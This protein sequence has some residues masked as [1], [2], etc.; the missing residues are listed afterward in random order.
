MQITDQ[1]QEDFVTPR[2]GTDDLYGG[3]AQRKYGD[4]ASSGEFCVRPNGGGCFVLALGVCETNGL[5][6]FWY[7]FVIGFLNDFWCARAF[8]VKEED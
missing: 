1:D 8:I 3:L 5:V 2:V 6:R 4:G 7:V